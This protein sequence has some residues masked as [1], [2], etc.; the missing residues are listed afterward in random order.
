VVSIPVAAAMAKIVVGSV[1]EI[2]DFFQAP[3][4]VSDH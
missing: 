3:P 1:E 2:I 4:E